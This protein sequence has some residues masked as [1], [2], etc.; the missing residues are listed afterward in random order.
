MNPVTLW[1]LTASPYQL[2]MQA[3][4]EYAGLPWR[5]W[6][7]QARTM[8]A[9]RFIL[10]LR[11]ARRQKAVQ[12]YPGM[13]VGMDEYPSVPYYTLDGKSL[14]Y[15]SSGLADHLDAL[16]MAPNWLVPEDPA[17]A[18]VCRLIDDAFD[19]FGLYMVHHNRWAV[20]ATTNRMG[21]FTAHE[22]RRLAPFQKTLAELLSRRQA[23]RCPYLFSV[24]P[25]NFDVGLSEKR[26]PPIR[27][28]FPETHSLLNKA[29]R[30]YLTAMEA[31]LSAQPY[32]LGE[33]FT[34]A[35]ASAY[36]QLGMNLVDGRAAELMAEL[37]PRTYA[38]L[39][40][41]AAG[42]HRGDDGALNLGDTLKPLLSCIEQTYVSLMQQNEQAY[43]AQQAAG[44]SLFN[45][46]AFDRGQ[47]LYDGE[48]MGRPFRAVVKTF[49]VVTWR[50]LL[51]SW[52]QL[53]EAGQASLQLQ[54]PQLKSIK[55]GILSGSN[56]AR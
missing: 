55:H 33:R 23:R 9:L 31:L 13:V 52:D 28:G 56:Q 38:W 17:M 49:Q 32:L 21:E 7:D 15:D 30:D 44:Q 48:L 53:G 35:D 5:R 29:W 43:E 50:E 2:K 16:G 45:E 39:L 11:R 37:A 14:Y 34:L 25:E 3:L 20:S 6:P 51:A 41:I 54:Y 27:P 46:A 42:D 12:R 4:L 47:A 26:T 1:G 18:F 22:L 40:R 19:E 8:Q 10:Q 36:G 24:A